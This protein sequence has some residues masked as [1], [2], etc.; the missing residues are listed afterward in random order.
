MRKGWLGGVER[1]VEVG[2]G[3]ALLC[4]A[5]PWI[6]VGEVRRLGVV[7]EQVALHHGRPEGAFHHAGVDEVFD[8]GGSGAGSGIRCSGI[9]AL[10]N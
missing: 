9:A 1:F 8:E 10:G 7:A 2:E 6:V 3:V 5:G 4:L